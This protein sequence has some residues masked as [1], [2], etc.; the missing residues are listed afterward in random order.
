M[1]VNILRVSAGYNLRDFMRILEKLQG[2]LNI[3]TDSVI[4]LNV[5]DADLF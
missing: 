5:S 4:Y 2:H 1:N 3:T